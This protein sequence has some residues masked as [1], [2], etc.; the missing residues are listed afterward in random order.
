MN[1]NNTMIAE[2]DDVI[3]FITDGL[4]ILATVGFVDMNTRE[5]AVYVTSKYNISGVDIAQDYIKFDEVVSIY[6]KVSTI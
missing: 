1:I 5:Y 3:S 4:V 2:V 6:K